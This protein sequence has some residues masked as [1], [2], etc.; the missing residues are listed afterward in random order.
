MCSVPLTP[1]PPTDSV[2]PVGGP[3]QRTMLA[4]LI[5]AAGGVVATDRLLQAMYGED[6]SSNSRAT[7]FTYISTLRR[8]LGDVIVRRGDGYALQCVEATIDAVE[9]EIACREATAAVRS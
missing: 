3:K 2:L 1:S 4:T 7:L 9:F 6:V 8:T 5:A